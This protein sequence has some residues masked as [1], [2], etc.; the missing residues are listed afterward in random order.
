MTRRAAYLARMLLNEAR[1]PAA[2]L[3]SQNRQLCSLVRHAGSRVPFYR[4][5]YA[6]HGLSVAAFRGLPDLSSLPIVD[7]RLMRAA[8]AAIQSLDAPCELVTIRTSGPPASR[9]YF[10]STAITT[11]GARHN[12]CDRI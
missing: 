5:L 7:K 4:D 12:P 8:G 6:A 2:L 3:A 10:T 9:S 11:N 1:T